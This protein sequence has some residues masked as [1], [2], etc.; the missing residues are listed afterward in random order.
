MRKETGIS[1]KMKEGKMKKERT[2]KEVEG[3][4]C[5]KEKEFSKSWGR[6]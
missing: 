2:E 6:N 5:M 4:N 1:E 3:R